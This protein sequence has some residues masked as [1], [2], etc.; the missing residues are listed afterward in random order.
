MAN[1]FARLLQQ[2]NQL[3]HGLAT[4]MYTCVCGCVSVA[5]AWQWI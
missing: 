5:Y 4:W 3:W 1:H 2:Q